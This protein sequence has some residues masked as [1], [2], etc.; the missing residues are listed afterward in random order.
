MELAHLL[1]DKSAD[2][3]VDILQQA[4]QVGQDA[5][6][7]KHNSSRL[8]RIWR[9]IIGR[10][11]HQELEERIR[12]SKVSWPS[13]N[14]GSLHAVALAVAQR[15]FGSL[16]EEIAAQYIK[17]WQEGVHKV[18]VVVL[19]HNMFACRCATSLIAGRSCRIAS[20]RLQPFGVRQHVPRFLGLLVCILL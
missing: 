1:C 20:A 8:G 7:K 14:H 11:L 15:V 12:V 3:F 18:V 9:R 19:H 4:I 6:L 5:T 17:L 13:P 16:R 2:K 10:T